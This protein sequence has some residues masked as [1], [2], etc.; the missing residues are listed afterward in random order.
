MSFSDESFFVNIL[1]GKARSMRFLI[2]L[3][4]RVFVK[5]PMFDLGFCAGKSQGRDKLR[6]NSL[7]VF[8]T[9]K[10]PETSGSLVCSSSLLITD[11]GVT[12]TCRQTASAYKDV[13]I[14]F[15]FFN[16]SALR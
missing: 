13:A 5:F 1:I 15:L 16:H 3:C 4:A 12:R 8:Q 6:G 14:D 2:K 9:D 7:V 11:V 10:I